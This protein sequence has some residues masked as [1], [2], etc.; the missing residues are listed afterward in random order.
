MLFVCLI[1]LLEFCKDRQNSRSDTLD[2]AAV[3]SNRTPCHPLR[4]RRYKKGHELCDLFRL[5]EPAD[6]D[7][8]RI[9]LHLERLKPVDRKIRIDRPQ[10]QSN[11][12]RQIIG[13]QR[14]SH[15]QLHGRVVPGLTHR[16]IHLVP[17]QSLGAVVSLETSAPALFGSQGL[18]GIDARSAPGGEDAGNRSD[19]EQGKNHSGNHSRVIRRGSVEHRSDELRCAC[20]GR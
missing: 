8:L 4:R 17:A 10:S 19:H 6:S 5:T 3:H 11:S 2:F 20:A 16:Y 9:F 13:R 15:H 12:R 1:L 18:H 14:G 7:F